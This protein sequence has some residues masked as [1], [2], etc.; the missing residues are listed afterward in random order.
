MMQFL[1][2]FFPFL[3]A[4]SMQAQSTPKTAAK[5]WSD[6]MFLEGVWQAHVAHGSASADGTYSFAMELGDHIMARHTVSI[7][8]CKGPSD[9]DCNHRDLLYVY[10]D[11]GEPSL[12]AIYFDSEGH[13][14]HY[15]ISI[16]SPNFAVFMTAANQPGPRFR[17]TYE[18]KAGVMYGKF[19]MQ[20]PGATD[21]K[22]YLE[23]SGP[24][25]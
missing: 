24:K 5:P 10:Q 19:Q 4:L 20:A 16:P 15:D 21:W 2:R 13:T 1:S 9:F 18:L 11:A 7:A 17:L 25:Q 23:W 6:L 3:L 12:K 22:S 8:G 14:L